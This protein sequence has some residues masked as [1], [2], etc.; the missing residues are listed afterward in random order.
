VAGRSGLRGSR[1]RRGWT[2]PPARGLALFLGGF[3]LLNLLV[4]VVGPGLDQNIWWI[5]LHSLPAWLAAIILGACAAALLAYGL[6]PRMSAW[7]RRG[8]SAAAALLTFIAL[9]NTVQFYRVWSHGDIRP[10]APLPLS[11]LL[12]VGLG[13]LTYMAARPA[14][15]APRGSRGRRLAQPL[16]AG[17]V[18]VFC[19]LAFP[20]VQMA[21]FGSTDYRRHA[22]AIVVLGAQVHKDGRAS[23]SLVERMDTAI[24]LYKKGYA[25]LMIVSGGR[26][27]GAVHEAI[28]MRD[29][30]VKA[31]VPA[32]AVLT[33]MNGVNTQATVDDTLVQLRKRH[34]SRV[35]VV[36]HFYHLARIK[37]AY[38]QKGLDVWTVPTERAR[39]MPQ[40][41]LIIGREVPGFWVYYLRGVG[42]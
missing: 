23:A 36:S 3:G 24:D 18:L 5:D 13:W 31:G 38:A 41:P 14:R 33:D 29:L 35:L 26:G 34:L 27:D 8:T 42:L 11:L 19:I 25:P 15:A 22:D 12:A 20:L 10:W 32:D 1:R 9:E 2:L 17:L 39:W 21:F 7:R 40:M 6:R 28:A 37:L 4:T 30:A 16:L